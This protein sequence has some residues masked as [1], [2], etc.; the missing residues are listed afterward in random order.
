MVQGGTEAGVKQR[1]TRGACDICRQKKIRCDSSI[2]PGNRCSNCIAFNAVCTRILA[3]KAKVTVRRF[4]RSGK[5]ASTMHEYT[6]ER[7]DNMRPLIDDILSSTYQ[8]PSEPAIVSSVLFSLASYARALE[9]KLLATL[10]SSNIPEASNESSPKAGAEDLV[11]WCSQSQKND[12]DW[13][14]DNLKA[15][16]LNATKDRIVSRSS[17]VGPVDAALEFG[18]GWLS[19]SQNSGPG[20]AKFRRP[21]F[22]A[23]QKWEIAPPS[24]IPEQP[25]VFPEPD[26]LQ[27]LTALYFERFNM[28]LPI[29]HRPTFERSVQAGLHLKDRNFGAVVLAVCANGSRYSKD[30][31]VICEGTNSELSSGYQWFRQLKM[32]RE[33][34]SP[35]PTL[36]EF[37]VY[38][39]ACMYLHGT[40][41][42]ERCWYLMG[43]AIRAAQDV[44]LHRHNRQERPTV[45]SELRKR[46][47]WALTLG[48]A[49][50]SIAVGRPRAVHPSDYDVDL[51]IACDDEY[52]ENED[53][54]L[55]F[56]QPPGRPS[57]VHLFINT[58]T[59]FN[60]LG[61]AIACF[62]CIKPYHNGL[63]VEEGWEEKA[64]SELDSSLNAWVD[65]VPDHLRWDPNR[66]DALFFDQS[67]V[68]F[69]T[70]YW[71]QI[72]VHRPFIAS[73]NRQTSSFS[74][75]AICTN[76]ARACSRIM[77]AHASRYN[78]L[79]LPHVQATL[80]ISGLVLL[81]SIWQARQAG[82]P[83]NEA[84]EMEGVYRC[85]RILA[86]GER[87]W[88][89]AG[90]F[91]D[92]LRC[93]S[94]VSNLPWPT[95][96]HS[97][98]EN[99]PTQG[100]AS[101]SLAGS[102]H[103]PSG[104]RDVSEIPISPISFDF[105]VYSSEL[106][107]PV[108]QSYQQS[109]S[110]SNSLDDF[111][112]MFSQ[113]VVTNSGNGY[114]AQGIDST[115][116]DASSSIS[117]QFFAYNPNAANGSSQA[118][119]LANVD[120]WADV[121]SAFDWSDWGAYIASVEALSQYGGPSASQNL[122]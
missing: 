55:A 77:E 118:M 26:L 90:R 28:V 40:S 65:A 4:R 92:V 21:E 81:I 95:A 119:G 63:R 103:V 80:L 18:R 69:N 60:I 114:Q 29:L 19:S 34:H 37:Q 83:L 115:F 71:V 7:R 70:Y 10:T 121:P 112:A 116:A 33:S 94:L 17:T 11:Q 97:E 14:A 91:H 58:L 86:S 113:S 99:E 54:S 101:T 85:A 45:E 32:C 47:W 108:F 72:I 120:L 6:G 25:L 57:F 46:I 79:P 56:K 43:L 117:D 109:D 68:L 20:L 78:M 22:W 84:R 74:S 62:Y 48:D 41:Q 23:I 9:D 61:S 82:V 98:L 110:N 30:P 12:L 36:D 50:I 27:H 76:A 49:V 73:R 15:L 67:A 1:R 16:G 2:T 35:A 87:K 107:K 96:P 111:E 13:L 64:L 93:L 100:A 5:S 88:Y 59:L 104:L 53:P 24:S 75:L 44:G 52:W 39:L 89:P 122:F 3:N 51:P 66:E 8:A 38:Y 106:S 31:R 42:P 105:P 102:G